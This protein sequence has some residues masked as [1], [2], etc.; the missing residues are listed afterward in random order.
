MSPLL[1]VIIPSC[2]R[3]VA[4]RNCLAALARQTLAWERF[5]VLIIDDGS[6]PPV[7]IGPDFDLPVSVH[8]QRNQGPGAARNSGA[9]LAQGEFLVFTDDD[10]LPEPEWLQTY[11]TAINSGSTAM[12]G[13]HTFNMLTA[14]P[15]A[16]TS[17]LIQDIVYRHYNA[18]PKNARFFASNNLLVHRQTFLDMG[19]FDPAFRTS[20]DRD[21]CDRW[22]HAGLAMEY[23]PGARVGH[24]HPLTLWRFCKQHFGYG[25][26]ARRYHLARATRGSGTFAQETGF[27]MNIN[28]WLLEPFRQTRGIDALPL[29]GLML[30]WQGA[31]A[32]GFFWEMASPQPQ[33]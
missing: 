7:N 18:A 14:N 21:L 32:L 1:S 33:E 8:R 20:E 19:G 27:H 2:N 22:R 6:E 30:I 11:A 31:N 12:L 17:Q 9:D 16:A 4:L 25:R 3:P 26:G 10:C 13:G 24:A 5:E 28:N 15:Y 29:A 23:V